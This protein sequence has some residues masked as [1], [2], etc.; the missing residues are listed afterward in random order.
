M[1]L[2]RRAFLSWS[3]AGV[4]ALCSAAGVCVGAMIRFL[5][6]SVYYEPPQ[7]FKIG[8]PEDFP[9]G[10]PTYL[11]EEKIYVFR[12]Q[13]KGFSVVSGVCTH[14]GCGVQWFNN[15]RR[16]HCPCHGSI[17]ATDGEVVHGPAPRPLEWLE[18]TQTRDGQL[19]V[20]KT[21]VVPASYRLIVKA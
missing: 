3:T 16:F 6:P 20:D 14:L 8:N 15:D 10:P 21:H 7:A 13:E 19:L 9:F 1:N 17:F 18:V 11:P 2:N 5:A 12:N 4:A